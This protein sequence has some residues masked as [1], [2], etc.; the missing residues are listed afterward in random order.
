MNQFYHIRPGGHACNIKKWN[1]ELLVFKEPTHLFWFCLLL[2]DNED[3]ENTWK[4]W[5]QK[6]KRAAEDEMVGWH[7]QLNGLESVKLQKLVMD[8]E[9]WHAA[10]HGVAESWAQL[11]DWTKTNW[12]F[13]KRHCDS[14]SPVLLDPIL[15]DRMLVLLSIQG[16]WPRFSPG[17]VPKGFFQAVKPTSVI[18]RMTN[19]IIWKSH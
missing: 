8:R 7:H 6:E 13:T 10:I 4:D 16:T 9:T 11:S 1:S 12:A 15:T 17:W 5:R 3:S 14:S 2:F 19:Y 18:S